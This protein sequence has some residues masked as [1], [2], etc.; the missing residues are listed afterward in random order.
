MNHPKL[1]LGTRKKVMVYA[2]DIEK[3]L[4]K[5]EIGPLIELFTLLILNN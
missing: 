5:V 4:S 2:I 3:D 1:D